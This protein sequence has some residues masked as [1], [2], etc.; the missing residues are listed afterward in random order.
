MKTSN[1]PQIQL[2]PQWN[3]FTFVLGVAI[4]LAMSLSIK[5]LHAANRTW[6]LSPADELWSNAG[7]WGGTAPVATDAVIFN[8]SAITNLNN[9]IAPMPLTGITFNTT[10][11]SSYTVTN[12]DIY[13]NGNI[14]DNSSQPQTINVS[15]LM[16]N[17]GKTFSVAPGGNLIVGG[18]IGNYPLAGQNN[19]ITL[20][21]NIA[22]PNQFPS[23]AGFNYLAPATLTLNGATANAYTNTTTLNAGTVLA[24]DFSN[25]GTPVNLLSTNA[26]ALNGATYSIKGKA[27]GTT[28]QTNNATGT[29]TI[30]TGGS[31]IIINNNGGAGTTLKLGNAWTRNSPATLNVDVS[32]GGTL[33]ASPA[34]AN[35]TVGY[36]TVKDAAGTGFATT[37]LT[38][39]N[40]ER[41][42]GST[43]LTSGANSAVTNFIASGNLTMSAASFAVN[44]LTLDATAG[45]GMLDL[46]GSADVMTNTSRGILMVGANNFS[47]NNGMIATNNG[48]IIIHQMGSGTLTLNGSIG[49]GSASLT[50]NGNGTLVINGA[51]TNT[52][53]SVI[54][55]GTVKLGIASAPGS[56]PF[57]NTTNAL[58]VNA[59]GIL[60]L[61]GNNLT[62]GTYSANGLGVVTNSA[63][64]A[65]AVITLGNGN[66]RLSGLNLTLWCGNVAI[67]IVGNNGT[68]DDFG[69]NIANTFTGGTTYTG[70]NL[71]DRA[72]NPYVFGFGPVTFGGSGGFTI[73]SQGTS[74]NTG[75]FTNPIVV[76]GSGNV[77]NY[78]ANANFAG[79]WTG[80]GTLTINNGFSP[81]FTLSGDISAFAGTLILQGASTSG[82]YTFGYVNTNNANLGGSALAVFDLQSLTTGTLNVQYNNTNTPATIRLGDLNTTGNTGTGAITV[83]NSAASTL[84]TYEVGA[85]HANSTFSGNIINNVGTVAVTKVGTG[86]WTLTGAGSTYTGPTTISNGVLAVNGV[87][88][89]GDPVNVFGPGGLG[90]SGSIIGPVTLSAGNAAI[91]L[92][93]NSGGMLSLSG[94][95]TLSNANILTFDIGATSDQIAVNGTTF[96]QDG[97][98][99]IYIA[100]AAGFGA[101]TYDLIT[102]APG[103]LASSFTLGTTFLGYSLALSNPDSSTLRLTVTVVAPPVAFWHNRSG[104][105]WATANNW[106]TN[107]TDNVALSTPPTI[108]TDVTFAANA[109]SVFSTTLGADFSIHSLTLSTPNNVTIGGANTLTISAGLTNDFSAANNV[110]NT[111]VALGVDQTWA[112]NSANPLTVN[113][114]ISGAHSLT[115]NDNS[116]GS[117]VLNG[118]NTYSGGTLVAN[119]T[120]VLGN[121]TN[122]LAD[123]GAVQV[124]N[125]ST[126][127]LGASSDTVGAVTLTSGN[128]TGTG[129]TLTGS[130]YG[131]ES[132][133]I[134]ANLGGAG[135]LTKI[136]PGEIV[137]VSGTNTYSGGTTVSTGTL[138]LGNNSALGTGN[139]TVA[140]GGEIDLN[141]SS[142]SN[143]I[144]SITGASD[145]NGAI[146]NNSA[147]PAAISGPIGS[148]TAN[149]IGNLFVY[150]VGNITL[151]DVFGP[152]NGASITKNGPG[153]LI[154]TGINNNSL[155][156]GNPLQ[157]T[158][159]DGTLVLAKT[160]TPG[161]NCADTIFI[162]NGTV[163]M[164]PTHL[165]PGNGVWN[166]QINAGVNMFGGT[167]D[168]N[169]TSGNNNWMQQI[170]GT[171][172]V[173]TNS[174]ATPATLSIR[175]RDTATTRTFAGTID[176]NIS[177]DFENGGAGSGR[178]NVLSGINTY[179]GATTNGYGTLTLSG[180]GSIGNSSLINLLNNTTLD[181]ASR[182][183]GTLTLNSGQTLMGNGNINGNLV[184]LAGSTVSPGAAV[185]TLRVTNNITLGG[186]LAFELNRTASPNHDQLLSVSGTITFGGTLTVTNLG[187]ALQVNDT[188]QLFSVAA[189][190]LDGSG[191]TAISL[192]TNDAT[193]SIYTWTN[194]VAIDGS[195][196][197]LSVVSPINTNPT[198]IVVSMTGNTLH[199]TWP[200]DHLGWTLQTNSVGLT[201]TSQ[202]FPYPGSA[203][204][205]NV[206]IT[207]NPSKPNVFFRLVYP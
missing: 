77:L 134:S 133:T 9:D 46:G 26:V 170:T 36:A 200:G 17:G 158:N 144:P 86:T 189:T 4:A 43:A 60:D 79:P 73:P 157:V 155:T 39:G 50:K 7:N 78:Q 205:T 164:D 183:D 167:F 187:A 141:G 138:Q 51:S 152:Q 193:G 47:I 118:V 94:G 48:E 142:I 128:I 58:T 12:N 98:A 106:D 65:P 173:I 190:N 3:S 68:R 130:S 67:K 2:R 15:L 63:G 97:T 16:T 32:A 206:D 93:N 135:T 198:N 35:G 185:G 59:G 121:P 49:T 13:L 186:K 148:P 34:T 112:N 154:L 207:I 81:T 159:N 120:L 169:G 70:N 174:S 103:I 143:S 181:A 182:N 55:R 8:D 66:N 92:T 88:A 90:G 52:G 37:N 27:S 147:S 75:S 165:S 28:V 42:T 84:V 53:T 96:T 91:N 115:I 82:N 99:T 160:T 126:L 124:V 153:T 11:N 101:G 151:S 199:L 195:I 24:L 102:G 54:N 116:G 5:P 132:G 109:A 108:P 175:A 172:G 56:G 114:N 161:A 203:S 168:L 62:V 125:N 76:N 188:F 74:F 72:I 30:G 177:I 111:K 80:S 71:T 31:A 184:T 122:T 123:A 119:G 38:T 85:L 40:I 44:S 204:V 29:F 192:A 162:N 83:R 107:A 136:G 25:M 178:I 129:G 95:L 191:F 171:A 61:N 89:G 1:R 33:L 145:G 127:S 20:S 156:G 45:N 180:D 179:T 57:G 100:Q 194:K 105:S 166:G 149:Q 14:T 117:I 197:V 87:L 202:W 140:N 64:G 137:L 146:Q 131:V 163:M 201:A 23:G 21:L 22:A 113:S 41:Y 18:V 6:V 19:G 196:Q 150:T 69:A 104:T 139:V 10:T 176:G 110:I